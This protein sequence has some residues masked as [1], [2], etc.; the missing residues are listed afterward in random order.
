MKNA[1]IALFLGLFG[2]I[3]LAAQCDCLNYDITEVPDS[4][5][6]FELRITRVAA[7]NF[8]GLVNDVTLVHRT[9]R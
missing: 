3:N 2:S 9:C 5:G 7:C 1:I 4:V 8:G 6:L